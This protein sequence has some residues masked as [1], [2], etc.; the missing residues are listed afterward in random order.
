MTFLYHHNVS[1]DNNSSE[2]AIRNAKVKI[3]IS[4]GFKS[5]QHSYAILR[6]VIDNA[7]KNKKNV[8][9]I[10]ADIENG[11]PISFVRPV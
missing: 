3:K 2:Q 11:I 1:P 6:S 4:G 5:L 8:L 7:I 10:L 9:N